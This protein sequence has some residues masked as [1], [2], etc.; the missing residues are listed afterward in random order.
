MR[1]KPSRKI[2]SEVLWGQILPDS[3]RKHHT[4]QDALRMSLVEAI[5]S[6][7]LPAG[8]RLPSTREL[9]QLLKIARI[10]VALTY[11][12]L[13]TQGFL[14]SRERRGYF[15]AP[16]GEHSATRLKLRAEQTAAPDWEQ[17]V[18]TGIVQD[19]WLE[20][21]RD[22]QS[23]PFPFVYGQLDPKLFPL[24]E[25]RECSRLAQAVP[26]SSRWAADAIDLDDPMLVSEI[27]T[28]VLPKRGIVAQADEVIVT[29]G[30][31]M[32]LFLLSEL[33]LGTSSTVGIEDPG[34]MDA[35][36]IFLRR[37]AK[38]Q[39]LPVGENGIELSDRLHEC[40]YVYCTPS[41]QCPTG[42]TLPLESRLELLRLAEQHDFVLIED[43]Y[44]AETQF[45]G[46]PSPALKAMDRSGRVIYVGSFSKILSPG[47]R[48]GYIVAPAQL[49]Q[50][51]RLLRRLIIR[52][53]PTNNQRAMALFIAQ[54]HYEVLLASNRASL[55]QR[56][57]RITDACRKHLPRWQFREPMGG[58]ALWLR[59]PEHMNM[60]KV[61][62][63]ARS[64]GILL[65]SG[66]VFF[67]EEPPG[68]YLRLAYSTIPLESIEPG[69]ERLSRIVRGMRQR[70]D[71]A[72]VRS[73]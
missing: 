49:I 16:R 11:E 38:L 5:L 27:L 29:L 52:H 64:H 35:R 34:Y 57:R 63:Q 36:N 26:D 60:L 44:D 4:L 7:K 55:E 32:A 43:D 21:P 10:T 58:S 30:T 12:R 33:L 68:N 25:W 14:E 8:E 42:A 41:H 1:T 6:G 54:G 13:A 53:P 51:A 17:R 45:V 46:Q 66:T 70:R 28:R 3:L 69:I 47:L 50:K 23:Y 18:V 59:A 61:T 40:D 24:A 48:I 71:T 37:G 22:W 56:A 39:R 73:R 31:Q 15:V 65:E 2:Q 20:K 72:Q 67:A 9:A 19:K 62:Q